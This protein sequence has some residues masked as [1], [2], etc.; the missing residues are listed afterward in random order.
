MITP[1][2]WD[3]GWDPREPA[4]G[5]GISAAAAG[6]ARKTPMPRTT[7]GGPGARKS[8][9]VFVSDPEAAAKCLLLASGVSA[10][11][12]HPDRY[13]RMRRI[14]TKTERLVCLFLLAFLAPLRSPN[15]HTSIH[16]KGF[17]RDIGALATHGTPEPRGPQ[18]ARDRGGIRSTSL[19]KNEPSCPI[20]AVAA[21][22]SKTDVDEMG[23]CGDE[24]QQEGS[25]A[26][27]VVARNG[28][29]SL[30]PRRGTKPFLK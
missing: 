2:T 10:S 11:R 16:N 12:C 3:A 15:Q 25:V 9:G 27:E 29:V 26:N 7:P 1:V 30:H 22:W 23:Y 24:A 14:R 28:S 17:F 21:S 4:T 5:S 8:P 20:Y 18:M 6:L 13:R 19:P